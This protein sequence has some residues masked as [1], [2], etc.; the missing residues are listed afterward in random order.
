MTSDDA[1]SLCDRLTVSARDVTFLLIP[2]DAE[3]LRATPDDGGWSAGRIMAH[4][5]AADDII[6]ARVAMLLTH[7]GTV[8]QDFDVEAGR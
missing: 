3:E 7:P 1:K 2:L 4:V 5:K 6:T 8:F